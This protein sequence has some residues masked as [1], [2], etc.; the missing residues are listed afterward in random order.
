LGD[1]HITYESVGVDILNDTSLM[2]TFPTH[3][4]PTTHHISTINMISTMAYQSL[5]SSDPR[6]V[7]S[8]LELDALGDTMPLNTTEASYDAIQYS[9]PSVD[10]QHL[11]ASNAYLFPSW[12]NSLSSSFDYISYIFPS[13]ESIMEILSV[14]E[15]P[16]DENHH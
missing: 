15:L 1:S 2:G 5:E 12:L 3:L 9:S 4:P 16:W 6:L 14:D 11:L 10:D 13:D 8:L 7:P